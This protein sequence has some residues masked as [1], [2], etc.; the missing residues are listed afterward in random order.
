[1]RRPRRRAT[2]VGVR[3]A[4]IFALFAAPAAA[5]ELE[6]LPEPQRPSRVRVHLITDAPDAEL[7]ETATPARLCRAPCGGWLE[8][9]ESERFVVQAGDLKPS[10]EFSLFGLSGDVNVRFTARDEV[11]FRL[12]L[13]LTIA[14]GV[15]VAGGAIASIAWFVGFVVGNLLSL[16]IS[17]VLGAGCPNVW[18]GPVALL[19]PAA[20]A[21][22]IGAALLGPGIA[23]LADSRE[24]LDVDRADD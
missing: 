14:G 8:T 4:L 6:L 10:A 5:Q 24:R 12:G 19:P 23:V 15:G 2:R 20:V 13:A 1:M 3:P 21:A 9:V 16:A 11:K 18:E 7:W 22:G 17:G